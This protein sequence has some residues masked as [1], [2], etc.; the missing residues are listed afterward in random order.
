VTAHF[1]LAT[2]ADSAGLL[3]LIEEFYAEESLPFHPDRTA[4]ALGELLADAALGQ[5]WWIE[6]DGGP[7]GYLLL[8]HSFILEFGGRQTFLDELYLRPAF[9]GRGVGRQALGFAAEASR[10]RGACALRLEVS[11]HNLR[12]VALYKRAGFLLHDRRTMT[13]PL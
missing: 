11:E 2:P 3:P 6:C 10:D 7:A 1:R 12:A 13:L 9:R 8:V 5:V 4:A